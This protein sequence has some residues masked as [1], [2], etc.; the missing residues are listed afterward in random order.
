MGKIIYSG[1]HYII[2]IALDVEDLLTM[3]KPL[4]AG[5]TETREH[6]NLIVG[7][8]DNRPRGHPYNEFISQHFPSSMQSHLKLLMDDLDTRISNIKDLLITLANYGKQS[9]SDPLRL[10]KRSPFDFVGSAASYLFGLVDHSEFQTLSDIIDQLADI[11]EQE[12]QQLN[13][14]ASIL[15]VTALHV[16]ALE[17]NQMRTR[18]A[19]RTL[20]DNM[21][22]INLTLAS[23]QENI[24]SLDNSVRM[25][26]A[27]SYA[28]S[29]MND[30]DYIYSR[31]SK[32][33]GS[34]TRGML[35]PEILPQP[36][37]W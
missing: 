17:T 34:M 30:L 31:F 12:R 19:I 8:V 15:N 24:Y 35:S 10:H 9:M 26:S 36:L 28:T 22:A 4:L 1:D 18:E 16:E 29:A 21:R 3:T 14:H 7:E 23:A 2:P 25:I 20:D 11:S 33:I 6:F 27:L 37:N 5:L 13:I 32:G